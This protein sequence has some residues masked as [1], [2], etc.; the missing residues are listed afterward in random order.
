MCIITWTSA[1]HTFIPSVS[2]ILFQE[3]L[4]LGKSKLLVGI[5]LSFLFSP[6]WWSAT[7]SSS[8]VF[9]FHNC[10]ALALSTRYGTVYLS[11]H[12]SLRLYFIYN[13]FIIL[14]YD[15]RF[16]VYALVQER[17]YANPAL[18]SLKWKRKM[19]VTQ[20][21]HAIKFVALTTH[22]DAF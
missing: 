16:G 14:L 5:F 20:G 7:S 4:L 11:H 15:F 10:Y 17:V 22:W 18:L 19:S 13:A 21:V 6:F 9:M 3:A 1:Q 2:F 12:S 8:S